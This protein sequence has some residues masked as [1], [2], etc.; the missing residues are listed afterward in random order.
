MAEYT[1]TRPFTTWCEAGRNCK[2]YGTE[3]CCDPCPRQRDY[4]WLLDNSN[5]PENYKFPQKLVSYE[6]DEDYKKYL[7]FNEYIKTETEQFVDAGLTMFLTGPDSESLSVMSAKFMRYYMHEIAYGNN[8]KNACWYVNVPK[9]FNKVQKKIFGD[10]YNSDP[11]LV[12]NYKML[13]TCPL[14]LWDNFGYLITCNKNIIMEDIFGILSERTVQ[15]YANLIVSRVSYSLLI[16]RHP[17]FEGCFND[18]RVIQTTLEDSLFFE[19]R[20]VDK[21]LKQVTEFNF[22]D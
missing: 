2:K 9:Y 13:Q 20:L 14:V 7:S 15:G 12:S 11:E 4:F 21:A 10:S 16:E 8:F 6:E 5:L 22:I 18:S 1:I 17:E 3:E 19:N